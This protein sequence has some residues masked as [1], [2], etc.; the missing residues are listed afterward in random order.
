MIKNIFIIGL[1]ISFTFGEENSS[2]DKAAD[3]KSDYQTS[4]VTFFDFSYYDD[5]GVFDIKR[6]YLKHIKKLSDK[7]LFK[8][9]LDIGRDQNGDFDE[10][11]SVHLKNA[12]ITMKVKSNIFLY[13]G[14]IDMNM[15]DI[16]ERTWGYRYIA[17]SSMHEYGFSSDSDFGVG[18]KQRFGSFSIS[19]LLTNGEGYNSKPKDQFQKFSLQLL[20]GNK[21]LKSIKSGSA[22]NAGFVL[23]L[24]PFESS[25]GPSGSVLNDSGG[26]YF[27]NPL[28]TDLFK[29]NKTVFGLFTGYTTD[30]LMMGFEYNQFSNFDSG[31]IGVDGGD[32]EFGNDDILTPLYTTYGEMRTSTIISTYF[33]FGISSKLNAFMRFDMYDPNTISDASDDAE[34]H[35]FLGAHCRISDYL[36]IAPSIKHNILDSS[37]DSTTDFMLNFQVKF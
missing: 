12:Q 35:I 17:K 22:F 26:E 1:F 6:T 25:F 4:G 14:L 13:L 28:F 37:V 21:N 8:I 30:N 18:Y 36:D 23:S 31:F 33:S 11:L 10:K 9:I 3:K 5:A 27:I 15:F 16:Q 32:Q 19:A 7:H 29:G 24:E 2:D 20:F 34:T